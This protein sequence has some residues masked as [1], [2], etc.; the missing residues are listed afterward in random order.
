MNLTN[1]SCEQPACFIDPSQ[2][3]CI[4]KGKLAKLTIDYLLC[5]LYM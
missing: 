1:M 2:P 4:A 3:E 5:M